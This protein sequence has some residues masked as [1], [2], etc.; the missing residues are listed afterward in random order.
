MRPDEATEE[1][2]EAWAKLALDR[3]QKAVEGEMRTV[4]M[5]Q[6]AK[7]NYRAMLAAAPE[8]EVN[9]LIIKK[10]WR[11]VPEEPTEAMRRAG[12]ENSGDEK[13][14]TGGPEDAIDRMWRAMLDAAP[15]FEVE[16]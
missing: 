15:E 2:G 6:G 7:E 3:I 13:M 5:V 9:S 1:M 8:F 16:G 10:N 12:L 14:R 4:G 11:F